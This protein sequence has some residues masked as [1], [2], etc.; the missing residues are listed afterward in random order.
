MFLGMAYRRR[1]KGRSRR[2]SRTS[3]RLLPNALQVYTRESFPEMWA[4][5]QNTLSLAYDNRIR[6]DR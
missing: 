2:K 1:F 4:T 3:D 6:G 5:I